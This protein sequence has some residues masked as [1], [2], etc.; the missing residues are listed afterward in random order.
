MALVHTSH[1]RTA[2]LAAMLALA[3]AGAT[4]QPTN[5]TAGEVALTHPVCEDAQGMPA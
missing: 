5:M 1:I 2:A 4:A 3:G